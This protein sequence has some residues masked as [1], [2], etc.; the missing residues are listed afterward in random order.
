MHEH[1]AIGVIRYLSLEQFTRKSRLWHGISRRTVLEDITNSGR[2]VSQER[3]T[4]KFSV[5]WQAIGRLSTKIV[6]AGS[7]VR[8]IFVSQ[9]NSGVALIVKQQMIAALLI[10]L[11]ARR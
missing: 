8:F 10:P 1:E 3:R 2:K 7:D 11:V 4:S 5:T 6:S 9:S